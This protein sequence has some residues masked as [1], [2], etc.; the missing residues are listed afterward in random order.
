VIAVAVLLASC[1]QKAPTATPP[2]TGISNLV[3][4]LDA[5]EVSCAA[6]LPNVTNPLA[7]AWLQTCPTAV[8]ASIT[9]VSAPNATV[10]ALGALNQF[11]AA[12]PLTASGLP[13][14]DIAVIKS[15]SGALSTFIA[16]YQSQITGTT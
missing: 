3:L 15:I 8:T 11:L 5:I 1:T 16:L 12:A 7:S 13:A 10:A 4:A 9:A 2:A 14:S 6:A